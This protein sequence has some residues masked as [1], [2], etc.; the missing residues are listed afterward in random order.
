MPFYQNFPYLP[1]PL[2]PHLWRRHRSG[3]PHGL[4]APWWQAPPPAVAHTPP[5]CPAPRRHPAAP[6]RNSPAGKDLKEG[7][8]PSQGSGNCRT[9]SPQTKRRHP[10]SPPD[11][12]IQSC[13]SCSTPKII[14]LWQALRQAAARAHGPA[15]SCHRPP[16]SQRQCRRENSCPPEPVPPPN[17]LRPP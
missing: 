17:R 9:L 3:R 2:K 5:P 11:S 7:S 10:P 6:E 15:S 12:R 4:P 14:V 1:K 16:W 8:L 13:C